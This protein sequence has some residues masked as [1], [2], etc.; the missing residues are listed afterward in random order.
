MRCRFETVRNAPPRRHPK[1]ANG[2]PIMCR[3]INMVASIQRIGD[4]PKP[5][6][7]RVSTYPA[8]TLRPAGRYSGDCT[9]I[10]SRRNASRSWWASAAAPGLSPW[11]QSVSASRRTGSPV[12]EVT[13]AS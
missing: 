6:S 7:L 3:A 2:K 13:D 8:Q 9:E 12:R 5:N 4:P 11:I 1:A 10:P